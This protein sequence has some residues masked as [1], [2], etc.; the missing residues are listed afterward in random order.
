MSINTFTQI[1]DRLKN[2]PS[3]STELIRSNSYLSPF[4]N[5]YEEF[6]KKT[7]E[8]LD[9]F[10]KNHGSIIKFA[11]G[12][13]YYGFNFNQKTSLYT[14]R[15]WL[16]NALEVNLIGE[17]N[18]WNKTNCP[19]IKNEFGVWEKQFTSIEFNLKENSKYKLYIRTAK[20]EWTYRNPAYCEFMIQDPSTLLF[21]SVYLQKKKY[22]WKHKAPLITEKLNIYECH[23]GMCTEKQEVSSFDDFRLTVLPRVKNGGYNA[24]QIMAIAEHAYYGSFGYHVT[25]FYASS[26]RFGSPDSL[27]QLIDVCHENGIL[28]L[29]DIVHSHFSSNTIEGLAEMDGTDHLYSHSGIKGKHLL[30]DSLVFDYSKYEVLRYLLSNISWWV[31]EYNVDGF[32][33]DGITSM[34]YT[35]HGSLIRNWH[36]IH[37]QHARILQ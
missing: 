27:K 33:F 30:W 16:P 5:K 21:D 22:E 10:N 37:R 2:I 12:Y 36:W 35:H 14:F 23:I 17:F 3:G 34:L 15:E 13:D 29:L 1:Y 6:R 7:I 8:K 24:V 19:L 28:V 18:E 4:A 25:G 31:N 26:S 32:R 9:L 20:N 11:E